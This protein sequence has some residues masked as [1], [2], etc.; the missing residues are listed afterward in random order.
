[1]QNNKIAKNIVF[2]WFVILFCLTQLA[3]CSF[4]QSSRYGSGPD[5]APNVD[6]DASKI[7]DAVPKKEVQ[8]PYNNRPYT[9]LGHRYH[10]LPSNKGYDKYGT[11]S[12]YGTK[13][14]GHYT[15]TNERYN[16]FAMTAAS[17]VLRIPCYA[18]VTNLAN[19]KSV[20][21]KVNDRGP[22]YSNRIMDLSYAAAKK[23]GYAGQGTA[24]VHIVALDPDLWDKHT[25]VPLYASNDVKPKIKNT[26]VK[27][28]K[29]MYLQVGA[30]ASLA[31]AEKVSHKIANMVHVKTR[32]DDKAYIHNHLVYRVQVGPFFNL[33]ESEHVKLLL[34]DYGVSKSVSV[35]G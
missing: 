19:G 13:F 2:R 24:K 26:E 3:A 35:V 25:N 10:V 34:E 18:K 23:I 15:S 5:T 28:T 7:P 4:M 17:T 32:I 20:V 31:S 9:V 30:F 21:V 11:A 16:L 12:W 8:S 1:M 6:F 33:E 29:K 27:T 14:H 22:F